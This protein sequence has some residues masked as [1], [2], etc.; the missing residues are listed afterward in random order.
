LKVSTSTPNECKHYDFDAASGKAIPRQPW[1]D[2][3]DEIREQNARFKRLA[4]D[5]K[6]AADTFRRVE[7]VRPNARA[8]STP[9]GAW[10]RMAP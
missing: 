2:A 9:A 1:A 6:D 7:G 5:E 8:S 10:L 3:D 4:A